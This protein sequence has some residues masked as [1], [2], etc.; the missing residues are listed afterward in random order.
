MFTN[1][2]E[3]AAKIDPFLFRLDFQRYVKKTEYLPCLQAAGHFLQ[4]AGHFFSS[5]NPQLT[6][7]AVLFLCY[8]SQVFLVSVFFFTSLASF[9]SW[10]SFIFTQKSPPCSACNSF[11]LKNKNRPLCLDVFVM[12]QGRILAL[13]V[14]AAVLV[15][16][17]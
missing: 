13:E 15:L 2:L 8:T 9:L 11:Q 10:T 6:E 5:Q 3:G 16:S 7:S 12:L 4:A 14:V 1:N 17:R